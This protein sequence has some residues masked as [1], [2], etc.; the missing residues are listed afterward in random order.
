VILKVS[1]NLHASLMPYLYASLIAKKDPPQ[2]GFD[3]IKEF[4]TS[5]KLDLSGAAQSDGA[6]GAARFT[7]AF[8]VSYLTYMQTRKDASVF[9]DALP[10]LGKDGTLYK[11]QTNSP[12]AGHVSAKTGT[13]IEED[14]LNQ[15]FYVGGKGLAGYI[16]TRKGEHLVL[17]AYITGVLVPPTQEA[18]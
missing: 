13:W 11:I 18:P 17:A 2:A 12:A 14:L 16:T 3:L 10:I 1:Q 9:H 7:P 6:G 8:M 4:L 5:A 15:D